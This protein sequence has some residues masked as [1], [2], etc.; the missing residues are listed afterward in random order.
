MDMLITI[1]HVMPLKIQQRRYYTKKMKEN[2]NWYNEETLNHIFETINSIAPSDLAGIA[3]IKKDKRDKYYCPISNETGDGS[4][5]EYPDGW[6]C[7]SCGEKHY[8]DQLYHAATGCKTIW[9]ARNALYRYVTDRS[10]PEPHANIESIVQNQPNSTEISESEPDQKQS[11]KNII[12]LE[13]ETCIEPGEAIN[14]SGLLTHRG[15]NLLDYVEPGNIRFLDDHLSFLALGQDWNGNKTFCQQIRPFADKQYRYLSRHVAENTEIDECKGVLIRKKGTPDRT[16]IVEGFYDGCAILQAMDNVQVVTLLVTASID[17]IHK[18]DF[19]NVVVFW[20]NDAKS[21]TGIKNTLK[22]VKD[23]LKGDCKVIDWG[24]VDKQGI[25][26]ADDLYQAGRTEDIAYLIE[27]AIP[28]NEWVAEIENEAVEQQG[29]TCK[30][31]NKLN[32]ARKKIYHPFVESGSYTMIYADTGVGKTAFAMGLIEAITNGD[33][34]W[35]GWNTPNKANVAYYDA[36]MAK[37]HLQERTRSLIRDEHDRVHIFASCFTEMADMDLNNPKFQLSV[38][39]TV[40]CKKIDVVV[41]DSL[42]TMTCGLNHNDAMDFSGID[43]FFRKLK[44]K[45]LAVVLLHHTGK[46]D[47]DQMGSHSH[48]ITAEKVIKLQRPKNSD[49]DR[50]VF[51]IVNKK[52]RGIQKNKSDYN[53]VIEL[54]PAKPGN[55]ARWVPVGKEDTKDKEIALDMV[56]LELLDYFR[57]NRTYQSY[58]QLADVVG[59]VKDTVRN[60]MVRLEKAGHIKRVGDKEIEVLN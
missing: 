3:G 12:N 4:L 55:M 33:P 26:D 45:G 11:L 54:L 59:S 29:I 9:E 21:Q 25:K 17:W 24:M 34:E 56:D 7:Y 10:L 2:N 40:R 6:Y 16:V 43:Q 18:Y 22:L 42:Q 58:R 8:N 31:L 39:K 44:A 32:I 15:Y 27:N 50:C 20:D 47:G 49:P 46:G 53:K 14:K 1:Y 13:N 38:I 30:A 51:E 23:Q 35:L 60:R 19:K 28:G 57:K 52:N 41:F 5:H 37:E 48:I 36:E